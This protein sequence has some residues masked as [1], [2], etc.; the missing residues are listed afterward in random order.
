MPALPSDQTRVLRTLYEWRFVGRGDGP[1]RGRLERVPDYI[2]AAELDGSGID[3]P[4]CLDALTVKGLAKSLG[5]GDSG[6]TWKLPGGRVLRVTLRHE[7]DG[8]KRLYYADVCVQDA[9]G[10]WRTIAELAGRD[11]CGKVYDVTPAGGVPANRIAKWNGSEWSALG[12][13]INDEGGAVHALAAFDDGGGPALYVGGEFT[14]VDGEPIHNIARWNGQT[15]SAVGNIE[16]P[17]VWTLK[18]LDDGSGPALFAAGGDMI[19]KWDGQKWTRYLPQPG[20]V[21]AIEVFDGPAGPMLRAGGSIH[22]G[23][24]PNQ[25]Y[26]NI[27]RFTP[28]AAGPACCDVPVRPGHTAG[29][30]R[31]AVRVG[32][33]VASDECRVTSGGGSGIGDRLSRVPASRRHQIVRLIRALGARES[34]SCSVGGVSPAPDARWARSSCSC[35]ASSGVCVAYMWWNISYGSG[36]RRS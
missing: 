5:P 21:S 33:R 31:P 27:A 24:F 36:R 13:G 6:G 20:P 17:Q 11:P 30:L 9:G 2:L 16:T 22:F 7:G 34:P 1:S 25:L 14:Q 8:P 12:A 32:S 26:T 4:A 15:W 23:E 10:P 28:A 19:Q 35:R 18:V 3:V 29:A